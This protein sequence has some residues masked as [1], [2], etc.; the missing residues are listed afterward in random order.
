LAT[1]GVAI[2]SFITSLLG[3]WIAG[4]PLGIH[5]QRTIDQSD[6]RLSGRGFATAGIVLG[7]IGLVG[8]IIMVIV[9]VIVIV[10]VHAASTPSP[11]SF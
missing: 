7:V 1:S 3:L 11:A 8:T 4:I 2:A 9:I 6:G 10:I 5:A